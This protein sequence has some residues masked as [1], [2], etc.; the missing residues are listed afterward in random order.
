MCT[1]CLTNAQTS[2]AFALSRLSAPS[3]ILLPRTE[4]ILPSLP[5]NGPTL[6]V[7]TAILAW[8]T[9][10]AS[11]T[12]VSVYRAYAPFPSLCTS[13]LCTTDLYNSQRPRT[14]ASRFGRPLANNPSSGIFLPRAVLDRPSWWGMPSAHGKLVPAPQRARS[15]R[16]A[17]ALLTMHL[18]L[19]VPP[20]SSALHPMHPDAA[21]WPSFNSHDS[22]N[23]QSDMRAGRISHDPLF[24]AVA[25]PYGS[26]P[27]SRLPSIPVATHHIHHQRTYLIIMA[28]PAPPPP[29]IFMCPSLPPCSPASPHPHAATSSPSPLLA[30]VP[31][32]VHLDVLPRASPR[33]QHLSPPPLLFRFNGFFCTVPAVR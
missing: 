20:W 8:R 18:S 10:S 15:S 14:L 33:N 27:E 1:Q 19:L 22:L 24:P 30:H 9:L 26:I 2:M 16:A 28:P 25:L 32:L 4:A 13:S 12:F 6:L 5:T 23:Q 21:Q 17:T 31:S 11:V 29:L 3:G 7:H